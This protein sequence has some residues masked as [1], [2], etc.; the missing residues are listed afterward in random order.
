[1][2]AD[3]GLFAAFGAGILS[4][5]SPCVL[6]LVPGYLSLMSGFNSDVV[7]APASEQRT[8]LLCNAALFVLGFSVV[9]IA[10]GAVASSVGSL[11]VEHK[12]QLTNVAGVLVIAMGLAM[13]G[14]FR[15]DALLR[16]TRLHVSPSRLGPYAAPVMGMAFAFGWT[17]CIGPVLAGVL[18]MAAARE[19]LGQG[20]GLLVAYSLG[21]G[22]PFLAA[23]VAFG[24]LRSTW[25]WF[26]RHGRAI[27]LISAA[28]LIVFGVLLLTSG[29]GP[30]SSAVTSL[31][32]SIGLDRFAVG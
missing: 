4:F 16:D 28:L 11:F 3:P 15:V 30:L 29:L 24:R 1:M 5:L 27:D 6:P 17:P 14:V 26:K 23:G 25:A 21:L 32:T 7:E 20:V 2:T 12:R 8:R 22:V 18:A 13:A 9:F 31:W 10:Y 19:T